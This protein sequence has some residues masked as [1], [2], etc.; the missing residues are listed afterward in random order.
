MPDRRV[1]FLLLLLSLPVFFI[2][3]GANSIWDANEAFYVETPRQMVLTGD[4]VR[5]S[6]NGLE[7]FNKPVLSYWIVAG[8]YQMFGISVGVERLGIALG[9][10][11]IIVATFLLG[12]SL[13][14][15]VTGVVA[16]LLFAT[17]PRI[18]FFSRRIFIDVYITLFMSLVLAFF[19]LALR[20]VARRRL[21]L[22]LMYVAMGLGVLTKG[23]MAVLLPGAV[24][25]VWIAIERRWSD[26]RHLMLIP[27]AL[28]VLGI[29]APWWIAV[30][31]SDPH[32][33]QHVRDFFIGENVGR[34]ASSMTGARSPVFFLGVLFADLLLPWAP[35]LA[36]VIVVA[37]RRRHQPRE[38]V[39][40]IR[41]LLWLWIAV[42]V[43]GFSLSASKED[44]YI[45]SV[46]PAV[47]ALIADTLVRT[48]FGLDDRLV[49]AG[50][51]VIAALLVAA[52][53]FV[54]VYMRH[55]FYQIALAT[56][57]SLM[58]TAAGAIAAGL[59]V[60]RR[61]QFAVVAMAAMCVIFNYVLVWRVLP[62]LERLKPVPQLVAAIRSGGTP[63]AQI[64]SVNMDLP[65]L[66]YY[67]NQSVTPLDGTRHAREYFAQYPEPWVVMGLPEW[68]TLRQEVP[69]LCVA[70]RNWV[71]DT[72][73]TDIVHGLPPPEIL[74]VKKAPCR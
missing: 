71:F 31:L 73:I 27:G 58:L 23:P 41:R 21:Y 1:F 11:G 53:V 14:A 10:M 25:A 38:D 16:A 68:E 6:F 44:L 66:V 42:I 2:A 56:P 45:F 64:G 13:G 4:Y 54:Y 19:V 49:S 28:I 51:A 26:L 36:V 33:W 55:G 20:D 7:R 50:V 39:A 46:I 47:A 9:A 17:A 70:L 62:A 48:R 69:G 59:A 29:V 15:R 3:L 57:I 37:W 12:R 72:R 35:L 67:A 61:P 40:P 63:A 30:G 24:F 34:F 60:A 52:G 5:P 43:G 18:V 65:S 32:G 74:L 22:T 8:L